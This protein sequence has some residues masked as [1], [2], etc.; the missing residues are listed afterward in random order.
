MKTFER[1]MEELLTRFPFWASIIL[2]QK[3]IEDES[4]D[5]ACVDGTSLRYNPKFIESLPYKQRLFVVAH[6]AGH[7]VLCHHLRRGNRDAEI[8]NIA[9]DYAIDIIL[10]DAGFEIWPNC[11]CD[12][13]Y[14]GMDAESIYRDLE[15]N[16]NPHPEQSQIGT[17]EDATNQNGSPLDESA[18][19][20]AIEKQLEANTQAERIADTMRNPPSDSIKRELSYM[21]NSGINW[22]AAL[23]SI[24]KEV[25]NSD[26]S[27]A[28]VNR[29]YLQ[30]GFVLPDMATEVMTKNLIFAFDTS[31]SISEEQISLALADA[32]DAM[33]TL[34][35]GDWSK[36]FLCIYCDYTVRGFE[37]VAQDDKPNPQGGGYTRFSPVFEFVET[38]GLEPKALLYFTDG[39]CEDFGLEPDY[40]VYW[41]LNCRNL[42]FNP[43]FGE[44]VHFNS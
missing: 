27:Y 32:F 19:E 37:Q 18:K 25:C 7:L 44:V 12:D 30:T 31:C 11:Y 39:E 35:Q 43:P 21:R 38:Q 15:T 36:E 14:R 42:R 24:A 16:G 34:T 13:K 29:H 41:V 40:P 23:N 6:E 5:T 22:S 28:Q 10:K 2:R 9:C 26:Y 4:I 17:I 33:N 20:D 3:I 1:I 8:W